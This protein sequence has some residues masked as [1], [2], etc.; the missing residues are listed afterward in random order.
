MM[1]GFAEWMLGIANDFAHRFECFH[2]STFLF[3]YL[4]QERQRKQCQTPS[5][6]NLLQTITPSDFN[7]LPA[8]KKFQ[9]KENEPLRHSFSARLEIN[10][11]PDFSNARCTSAN[12]AARIPAK[13]S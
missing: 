6:L 9:A 8:F 4:T 13:T 12:S 7:F 10:F 1:F 3:H 11:S 2:H 5:V